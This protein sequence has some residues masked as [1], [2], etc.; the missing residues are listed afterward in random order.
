MIP[1]M[2]A[3]RGDDDFVSLKDFA[4]PVAAEMVA[5]VLRQE[6]IRVSLSGMHHTGLLGVAGGIIGTRLKVPRSDA[7]RAEDIV[8]AMASDRAEVVDDDPAVPEELRNPT[9]PAGPRPAGTGPYREPSRAADPPSGPTPATTFRFVL[10]LGLAMAA[11]YVV[12]SWL[13]R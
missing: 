7:A 4:D 3:A 9:A 5:D 10:A 12:L 1:G 13:G 11:G 6:G 2:S 8:E